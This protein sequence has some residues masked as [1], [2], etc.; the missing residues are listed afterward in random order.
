[1]S[2][3]RNNDY[4][5]MT[6]ITPFLREAKTKWKLRQ[7]KETWPYKRVRLHQLLECAGL[8]SETLNQMMTLIYLISKSL[9]SKIN[10]ELP[11]MPGRLFLP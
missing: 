7:K 4:D 9:T 3:Y 1:M 10:F 11:G 8:N 6:P 2:R 5:C